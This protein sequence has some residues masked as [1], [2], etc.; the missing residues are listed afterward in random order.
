MISEAVYELELL[1]KRA[2]DNVTYTLSVLVCVYTLLFS[3]C[4]DTTQL[5]DI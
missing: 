1:M 2:E 4:I 5:C 3:V